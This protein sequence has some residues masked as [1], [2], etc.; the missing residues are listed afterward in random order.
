M[1]MRA[2]LPLLLVVFSAVSTYAQRPASNANL[3]SGYYTL[4]NL[5]SK[6]LRKPKVLEAIDEILPVAI[7]PLQNSR[8]CL[9]CRAAYSISIKVDTVYILNSIVNARV[10]FDEGGYSTSRDENTTRFKF[11][12]FLSVRDSMEREI[13][14]LIITDPDS[15][16]TFLVQDHD[17][18]NRRHCSAPTK[19]MS[20]E[21]AASLYGLRFGTVPTDEE[22]LDFI[23]GKLK[24]ISSWIRNREP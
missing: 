5:P 2:L 11:R 22:L 15:T 23:A 10:P 21:Y 17:Y 6:W 8:S 9:N 19:Y 3:H 12:S 18:E 20:S 24:T 1:E 13:A 7:A 14:R 4:D 16:E